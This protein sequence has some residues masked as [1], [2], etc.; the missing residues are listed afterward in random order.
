LYSRRKNLKREGIMYLYHTQVGVKFIDYFAK[1]YKKILR[2][3]QY[4]VI[5]CGYILMISIIY[6]FLKL[7]YNYI[8]SPTLASDL[9]V[10]VITPLVPYIGEIFKVNYFPSFYFT[11]W[12]IV[13]AIIA[14]FH[15]FAHGI[16]ARL[17]NIKVKSTGFGFLGPFLA[18]FVNPDEKQMNKSSKTSQLSILAAGTFANIIMT[19]IFAII[20]WLFFITTFSPAGV[21]FNSYSMSIINVSEIPNI[22]QIVLTNSSYVEININ[23]RSYVTQ[24][25][26][27]NETVKNGYNQTIVYDNSP[28]LKANLTG[29]ITEINGV[30][31]TNDLSLSKEI[32]KY[33]PG[34]KIIVKTQKEGKSNTFNITL[35]EKDGKTYLGIARFPVERQGIVSKLSFFLYGALDPLKYN[36]YVKGIDYQPLGGDFI[37][38]I[39]NLLWWI[40]LVNLSVALFNMVPAGM[41]DGGRFFMITIWGITGNKKLAE[42]SFKW[43]TWVFLGLLAL[44]MLKWFMILF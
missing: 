1:K 11:Y 35:E 19:V 18:A 30:K 40:V 39:Y 14:V 42:K 34:D 17:N 16:F 22:D 8:T 24:P 44:M 13:I 20:M 6:L 25:A 29:A 43:A 28:A 10:P 37:L 31:I 38:F 2:P 21:F 27:L 3:L 12:I 36:A 26:I 5:A 7:T 4:L 33:Q 32:S 9:K 15:E 23:N 41:F